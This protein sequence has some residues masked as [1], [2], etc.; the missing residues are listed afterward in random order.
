MKLN[1][2]SL[3]M[4]SRTAVWRWLA[5]SAALALGACSSVQKPKPTPL[6]P[7]SAKIAGKQVWRQSLANRCRT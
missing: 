2:L 7:L 3:N 5:V 1:R 4:R 6:E